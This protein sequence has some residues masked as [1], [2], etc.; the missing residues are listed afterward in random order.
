MEVEYRD[1]RPI[2]INPGCTR[3]A[4]VHYT[5]TRVSKRPIYHSKCDAC[6]V[7]ERHGTRNPNQLKRLFMR[8]RWGTEACWRCGWNEAHTDVHRVVPGKDGGKYHIENRIFLCPNCHRLVTS[9]KITIN[10]DDVVYPPKPNKYTGSKGERNANSKLTLD[11]VK[12]IREQLKLGRTHQ[13]IAE[14]NDV[15]RSTITAINGGILWNK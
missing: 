3:L 14:E 12:H 9:G 4:K 5:Q 13:S 6:A 10:K 11:K 2:C 1:G 8:Q 7:F 15:S